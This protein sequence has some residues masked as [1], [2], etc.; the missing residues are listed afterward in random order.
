MIK[1]TYQI[2]F[3]TPVHVGTGY[4][5]AGFL[6]SVV[7]RDGQGHIYLPG[8]SIKGKVRQQP[9]G[10]LTGWAWGRSSVR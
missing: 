5:F 10:W 8:S 9:V 1:L 2:H 6:D 4:G 7:V 3:L